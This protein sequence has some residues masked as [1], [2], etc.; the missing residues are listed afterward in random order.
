[1]W[2]KKGCCGLV[3]LRTQ[4]M[5]IAGLYTLL[6]LIGMIY[7]FVM[8]QNPEKTFNGSHDIEEVIHEEVEAEEGV[9][10]LENLENDEENTT[11][12]ILMDLANGTMDP[13]AEKY[14]ELGLL[15]IQ[16]HGIKVVVTC[17]VSCIISIL[18]FI[19]ARH[20]R[21]LYFVPWLTEQVIALAVGSIQ[22][23]LMAMGG[24][25]LHVSVVHGFIAFFIFTISCLF[26]YSVT[27]HFMLLRAMKKHSKEIINSVM[28][29]K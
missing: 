27:S 7:G 14:K 11:D 2:M 1:M 22:G 9:A 24:L 18:L 29:G 17:L 15:R 8:I 19:G 25:L 4:T 10:D 26:I 16:K 23:L 6:A 5:V 13:K 3:D 20:G 28:A 21:S 12:Q